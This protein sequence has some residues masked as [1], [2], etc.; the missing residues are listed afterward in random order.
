M[1]LE[2]DGR[3]EKKRRGVERR[4]SGKDERDKELLDAYLRRAGTYMKDYF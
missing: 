4:K 3:R 1:I 2:R